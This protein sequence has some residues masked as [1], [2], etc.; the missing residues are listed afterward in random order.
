MATMTEHKLYPNAI[1]AQ[2]IGSISNCNSIFC[3]LFCTSCKIIHITGVYDPLY[4]TVHPVKYVEN[5]VMWNNHIRE[6]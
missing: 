5:D 3:K 2:S 6:N 4:S 1:V